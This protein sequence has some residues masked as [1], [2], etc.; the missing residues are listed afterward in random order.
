MACVYTRNS[1]R[2]VR[3][4]EALELGM[5]GINTG[6]VSTTVAPFGGVKESG[7]GLEG[8]HLGLH[9]YLNVKLPVAEVSPSVVPASEE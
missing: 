9:D 1:D 6:V 7:F 8:S 5:I 4:C 2:A 3:V